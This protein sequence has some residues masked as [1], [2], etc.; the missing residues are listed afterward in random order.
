MKLF[1]AIVH[2][3]SKWDR[4][5][6]PE[7]QDGFA[8]H[9]AYMGELE[10]SGFI[11]LAGLMSPSDDVLFVFRAESEEDVRARLA[12]DPLQRSGSVTLERIEELALRVSR[13]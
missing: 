10:T 1:A 7:Q 5:K 4:S 2:R 9:V 8:D 12:S 6:P 3:T 11:A 13:L